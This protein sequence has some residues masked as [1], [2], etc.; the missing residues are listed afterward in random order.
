MY[1]CGIAWLDLTCL[2]SCLTLCIL[3]GMNAWNDW[4]IITTRDSEM[5]YSVLAEAR[6]I[7]A[8]K[9]AAQQS[10]W[11]NLSL[12]FHAAC[13]MELSEDALARAQILIQEIVGEGSGKTQTIYKQ[14]T[15]NWHETVLLNTT[16]RLLIV[17][18]ASRVKV[19]CSIWGTDQHIV[20]E[21]IGKVKSA[22]KTLAAHTE[23]NVTLHTAFFYKS[24]SVHMVATNVTCPSWEEIAENYQHETR[25]KIC[26]LIS[27]P[28]SPSGRLIIWHGQ[29][30]T[31]KTF[32]IR[33]LMRAW[34]DHYAFV[35]I[36]DAG[37]FLD[38]PGSYYELVQEF[39]R[40]VLFIMEDAA[41]NLL[42]ETRAHHSR[43]ISTILNLTEGLI[44]QGRQDQ[45]LITFNQEVRELD[46]AVIRPGRCRSRIEFHP[47]PKE[48]AASWLKTHNCPIPENLPDHITLASLFAILHNTSTPDQITKTIGFSP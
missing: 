36:S 47:L 2:T 44:A 3:D 17:Y 9:E 31:G 1:A 42:R 34:K 25:E 40:P 16:D 45:F 5:V 12:P 24:G 37:A 43:R 33:A 6:V 14:R 10:G 46:P 19:S 30:G 27:M 32:A 11:G 4:P 23:T 21:L 18:D 13:A 35:S 41:E 28:T 48:Y 39:D 26:Q 7:A 38:N 8:I 22:L 29:P 20:Q 15:D